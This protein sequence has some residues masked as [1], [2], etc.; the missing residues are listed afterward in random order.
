MLLAKAALMGELYPFGTSFLAAVCVLYP[1]RGKAA[2]LGVMTGT[3]LASRDWR[4]AG[5]LLCTVLIFTLFYRKQKKET[6]WLTV[7]CLVTAAHLLVRGALTVFGENELYQWMGVFFEAFFAG[8]LTL[9]AFTGIQAFSKLKRGQMLTPE[10]RTSLGLIVLGALVGINQA[11][12]GGIGLQSVLSRW[13]VLCGAYLGGPGAGAATGV[14]VGLAPCVQGSLT[15]GPIALY[16]LAGLLG[17]LFNN[18]KKIGVA[19]GFTLAVLLLSLFFAEQIVIEKAFLETALAV[20]VFLLGKVPGQGDLTAGRA[21]QQ[22]LLFREAG[23]S[24]SEKLKKMAEVF[25]ELS[26]MFQAKKEKAAVE[27]KNELNDLFNRVAQKVCEG[28]SLHR[29]CWKQD[30]YRTYRSLLEAC[31]QLETTGLISEKDFGIDLKRR[32]MRLRELSMTLNTQLEYL[33]LIKSYENQLESCRQLV[34]NQLAGLAGVVEDFSDEIKKEVIYKDNGERLL[35]DKLEEKGI[36]VKEILSR[37]M[38]DGE[39]ELIVSQAVCREKNWCRSMVAPNVSQICGKNYR[40][41]SMDCAA[42]LET[43]CCSYR[44]APGASLQV[45]VGKAQCPKDGL[46]VSG[47]VC[48]T[49]I[50][51]DQRFIMVMSDGMGAGKEARDE[52]LAAVGLFEKLMSAGFTVDTALKTVN[53]ALFL[54]S[55]KE[56]FVTMDIVL[57]N[58]VSGMTDFIKNGGAPSLVLTAKGVKVVQA[59]APP[60]GILDNIE[61]QTFRHCL[62]PAAVIILM[63]DGVWEAVSNAVGPA[64]WLEDVLKKLDLNNPQQ[65]ASHLLYLA[66]KASGNKARDDLCIL[67]AR[68]E[69]PDIA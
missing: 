16:A 59:M 37:E 32:C 18:C 10:E 33:G 25:H 20:A 23:L 29:V 13:L 3:I 60:A 56:K 11:E 30:F 2:L 62:E 44:L 34:N 43:A 69:T 24:V 46:K 40:I 12:L 55:G 22:G 21:G 49:F 36:K 14:G 35:K 57:I 64:G 66:R 6:H 58:Q 68:L 51:P 31:A 28:C 9:V 7:P 54:R 47:D 1:K 8:V 26:S 39:R 38:A 42:Q 63:S 65:V 19:V 48:S 4:L 53:T 50:L 67:V 27:G 15:T 17:G 52:S 45:K 41:K 5:Y 61:L